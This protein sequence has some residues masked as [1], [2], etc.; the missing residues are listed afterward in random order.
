MRELET[1][2]Q[3]F[4]EFV[5]NAQLVKE[6]AAPYCVRW[7]RRL[8]T[9]PASDEPLSTAGPAGHPRAPT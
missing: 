8:R 7:V 3:Q 2:L 9:R 5:L 4:G 1:S 6:H